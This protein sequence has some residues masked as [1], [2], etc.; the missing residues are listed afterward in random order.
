MLRGGYSRTPSRPREVRRRPLPLQDLLFSYENEDYIHLPHTLIAHMVTA[1]AV[2][3]KPWSKPQYFIPLGGMVIGN[4]MNA[5]AIALQRLLG[6]LRKRRGEVEA[7][8]CLGADYKD[9]GKDML[10][11]AMRVGAIPSINSMMAIGVAFIPD[12]MTGQILTG[13][14]PLQAVRY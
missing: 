12:L 14:D 5:I 1:V 3:V 9:A 13:A 4:S 11:M 8:Q 6:E 10:G 2:S 7:M